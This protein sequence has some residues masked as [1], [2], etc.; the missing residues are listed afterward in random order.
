MERRLTLL[1]ILAQA[2]NS[3]N[4]I[5][6]YIGPLVEDEEK[7]TNIAGSTSFI[8][9]VDGETLLMSYVESTGYLTVHT[10]IKPMQVLEAEFSA[11]RRSWIVTCTFDEHT[12]LSDL[13]TVCESLRALHA[14]NVER[15]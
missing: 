8:L 6:K 1:N 14:R 13:I 12:R 9:H 2:I 15:V 11:A 3:G 4:Y 7:Q 5:A 10:V